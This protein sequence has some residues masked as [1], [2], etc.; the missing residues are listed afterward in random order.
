[1]KYKILKTI[2]INSFLLSPLLLA[3]CGYN[4][5]NYV[6]VLSGTANS[7][8]YNKFA[9]DVQN[10]Y[11]QLKNSND[12]YKHLS[13]ITI[14]VKG[15]ID[16]NQSKK[17]LIENGSADFAF[18]SSQS[19][20]SNNFYQKVNPLIQTLTTSFVFDTNMDQVYVDGN[21][22]DPLRTIASNMQSVSF[23]SNYSYPFNT[24]K[25]EK[26]VD[27]NNKTVQPYYDWNGIRYNA[28]YNFDNSTLV[29]GYRGMILLSGTEQQ[30]NG[31][32][33]AW[34]NKNWDEFR[35]YGI[36]TGE[37][38][39]A[40][41][42]L[43]QEQLIKKH[44][45]L[46]SSNWTIA[47][48]KLAN[49]NKYETDANGGTSK[50]GKYSNFVISFTDEGSFAWTHN[51]NDSSDYVPINGNKIKI[52]SVTNPA[53]YDVGIFNKFIDSEVATLLS[54]VIIYLYENNNNLY[55]EGLGYNGYR[56]I[57]DFNKEVLTPMVNALGVNNA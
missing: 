52:F 36:I 40:G 17:D 29:N 18:I 9:L 43:L 24:W 34:N 26:Q 31:A 50:I 21:E 14:T 11:N 48:D 27:S 12:K 30:I 6:F 22:S 55:G 7:G 15:N 16:D 37:S 1:M 54:E 2:S 41:T 53:I 5:N 44:F 4:A 32:I 20:V 45:N 49:P 57:T 35:N 13:D 33:N 47:E 19:L 39:S 51:N 3:S 23:G 28:F 56:K 38:G 10:A 42:Y 8:D 25:D 46:S